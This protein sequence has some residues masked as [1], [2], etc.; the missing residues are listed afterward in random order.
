M[1]LPPPP[2]SSP[3]SPPELVDDV[4]RDIFLLIPADDPKSLVR[5]A[6]VCTRW[7]SILSDVVFTREYRT[8]HGTPPMLGFLHNTIHTRR[9]ERNKQYFVPTTSFRPPACHERC[10][11]RALDSRHGLVLF[12]TSKSGEDF[13][14]WDPDTKDWWR[15]K[16]SD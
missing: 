16:A 12:H 11:L 9:D 5:A 3:G 7:Q 6:A 4:M 13:V 2:Q 14:V 8:L 1:C 15:I 10:R